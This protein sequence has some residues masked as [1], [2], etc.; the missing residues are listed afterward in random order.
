MGLDELPAP[1]QRNLAL[2]LGFSASTGIVNGLAMLSMV[3]VLGS[4]GGDAAAV[5]VI[6]SAMPA[7]SIIQP[8]WAAAARHWRLKTLALVSG[9]LRCLP[10]LAVAFITDPWWFT[11]AIAAYYLLAGPHS[12][13]VPSLYKYNYA[14]SHRGRIIGIL[15]MMQ[16]GL[17]MPVMLGG[18]W[19]LDRD[20]PFYR[21][22]C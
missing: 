11:A 12:L 22:L 15:R 19:L 10:L 13:A 14:D 8:L 17:A 1:M 6:A 5:T 20:P 7:T 2:E 3:T 4:L 18:A 21:V 9:A 16:Q